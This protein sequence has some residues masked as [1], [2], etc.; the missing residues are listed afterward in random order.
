MKLYIYSIFLFP[1][2]LSLFLPASVGQSCF[3]A[4]VIQMCYS[5]FFYPHVTL[6]FNF[7]INNVLFFFFFTIQN[8][9]CVFFYLLYYLSMSWL[10]IQDFFSMLTTSACFIWFRLFFFSLF[11]SPPFLDQRQPTNQQR[12]QLVVQNN[13][14]ILFLFYS[15][16]LQLWSFSWHWLALK[17]TNPVVVYV[18][19]LLI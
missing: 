17:N 2:F 8:L 18:C 11:F 19:K 1:F 14:N 12:T 9:L 13:R 6:E 3:Y 15:I 10:F 4:S 5:F 16:A 7:Y